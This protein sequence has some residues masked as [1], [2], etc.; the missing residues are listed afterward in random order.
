[1][2]CLPDV[3]HSWGVGCSS[4]GG[5]L[6]SMCGQGHG[7]ET[8][9]YGHAIYNMILCHQERYPHVNVCD[10]QSMLWCYLCSSDAIPMIPPSSVLFQGMGWMQG[11]TDSQILSLSVKRTGLAPDL[12]LIPSASLWW[13]KFFPLFMF[14]MNPEP[15]WMGRTGRGVAMCEAANTKIALYPGG[16]SC[17]TTPCS[18]SSC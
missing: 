6:E 12:R 11:P 18:Q 2:W 15:L 9:S 3:Y 13:D 16:G 7:Y 10:Q 5:H 14:P 4:I 1:M 8:E 17:D